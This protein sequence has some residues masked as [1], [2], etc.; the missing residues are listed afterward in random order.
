MYFYPEAKTHVWLCEHGWRSNCLNSFEPPQRPQLCETLSW[1]SI[2]PQSKIGR[3][4]ICA[5][6][7][8]FHQNAAKGCDSAAPNLLALILMNAQKIYAVF[9]INA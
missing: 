6:C 8:I 9:Q 4:R 3:T 5:L 1:L 2:Y 7:E